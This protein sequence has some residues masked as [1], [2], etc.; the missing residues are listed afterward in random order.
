MDS[1][2]I[3]PDQLLAALEKAG[4]RRTRSTLNAWVKQGLVSEPERGGF[5]RGRGRFSFYSPEAVGEAAAAAVL[6]D[7]GVPPQEVARIRGVASAEYEIDGLLKELGLKPEPEVNLFEFVLGLY[8]AAGK[9]VAIPKGLVY[10]VQREGAV[11]PGG[12]SYAMLRRTLNIHLWVLVRDR[13]N[14]G[15][16]AVTLQEASGYLVLRRT[17]RGTYRLEARW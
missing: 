12:V 6:L 2:K 8:T 3:T 1:H 7:A 13:V 5:G 15:L 16:P 14:A 9:E 17:D 10:L 4:I 11:A